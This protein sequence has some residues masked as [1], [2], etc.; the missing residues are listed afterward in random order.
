MAEDEQQQQQQ[1]P[2][3]SGAGSVAAA[4]GVSFLGSMLF[5]RCVSGTRV[6]VPGGGGTKSVGPVSFSSYGAHSDDYPVPYLTAACALGVTAEEIDEYLARLDKTMAQFRKQR[7]KRAIAGAAGG[8]GG[9]EGQG[10]QAE[11][12]EEQEGTGGDDN[13]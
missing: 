7:A 6:V 2:S 13:K 10:A 1:A 3:S 8:G 4:G 12:E 11:G 5:M 9:G